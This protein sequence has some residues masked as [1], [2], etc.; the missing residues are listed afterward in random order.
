VGMRGLRRI[1]WLNQA[2]QEDDNLGSDQTC[3]PQAR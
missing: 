3:S 2:F 1:I